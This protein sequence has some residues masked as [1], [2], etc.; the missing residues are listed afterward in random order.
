MNYRELTAELDVRRAEAAEEL[1]DYAQTRVT[2]LKARW[3]GL[4]AAGQIITDEEKTNR[5][6]ARHEETIQSC[7]N[8]LKI[9][10]WEA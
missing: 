3:A 1:R 5:I 10:G 8:W 2:Y 9:N 7:D 6:I 4:L